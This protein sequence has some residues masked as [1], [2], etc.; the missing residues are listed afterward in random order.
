MVGDSAITNTIIYTRCAKQSNSK[1][2]NN[3]DDLKC[4]KLSD[5]LWVVT[6]G[7]C[8]MIFMI[9]LGETFLEV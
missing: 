3:A 2:M 9:I 8:I 4:T 5:G 6:E 7:D 1:E